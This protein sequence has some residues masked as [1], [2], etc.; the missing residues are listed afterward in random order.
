MRLAF[1]F[2]ATSTGLDAAGVGAGSISVEDFR[3]K[4]RDLARIERCSK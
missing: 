2:A 1:G 3:P 4:P